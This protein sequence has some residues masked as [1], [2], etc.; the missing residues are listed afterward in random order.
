MK[1]VMSLIVMMAIVIASLYKISNLVVL[2]FPLFSGAE[3]PALIWPACW[4]LCMLVG[5]VSVII[6]VVQNT[7]RL[8]SISGCVIW[9]RVSCNNSGLHAELSWQI[10]GLP[11]QLNTTRDPPNSSAPHLS[12][13]GIEV[14]HID[15]QYHPYQPHSLKHISWCWVTGQSYPRWSK[16]LIVIFPISLAANMLRYSLWMHLLY[17]HMQHINDLTRSFFLQPFSNPWWLWWRCWKLAIR[18]FYFLP[19]SRWTCQESIIVIIAGWLG[20]SLFL[21]VT[22]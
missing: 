19:A 14:S 11:C 12:W 16:L 4:S 2:K 17:Y 18:H 9:E 6:S 21:E 3:I 13:G 1:V 7:D 15:W 22:S 5:L 20:L 10:T 8:H